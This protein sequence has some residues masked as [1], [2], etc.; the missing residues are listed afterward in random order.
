[1]KA[2]TIAFLAGLFLVPAGRPLAAQAASGQDTGAQSKGPEKGKD[3]SGKPAQP[4]P[5][6]HKKHAALGIACAE[7]HPNPDPGERMTLPSA[8]YCMNCHSTIAKDSPAIRKLA[9]YAKS[10][11]PVPWVRVCAVP[12]WVYWNH[13]SHLEAG[14]A[15]EPCHGK[16]EQMEVMVQ[17]SDVTS[18][19]GCAACH[20]KSGAGT[21]CRVCH[22]DK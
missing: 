14:L 17:A 16:V 2:A 21:G 19:A 20:R 22:A 13:R 10:N 15:C 18:M 9:G 1:M 6:S 8:A 3:K 7:C 11:Q 5:Y 4:V 12:A